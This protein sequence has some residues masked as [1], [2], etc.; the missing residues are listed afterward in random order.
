MSSKPEM[1]LCVLHR[2]PGTGTVVVNEKKFI[3]E[4]YGHF[5][6]HFFLL[7]YVCWVLLLLLLLFECLTIIWQLS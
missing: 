7:L 3:D 1:P 5:C 2:G 4:N 6:L